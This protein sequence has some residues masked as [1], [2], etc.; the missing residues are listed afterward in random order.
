MA[1]IDGLITAVPADTGSA[2]S[3]LP[4]EVFDL[5][6]AAAGALSTHGQLLEAAATVAALL[7]VIVAAARVLRSAFLVHPHGTRG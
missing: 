3:T 4:A 1:F 5:L 6:D 7:V 2:A